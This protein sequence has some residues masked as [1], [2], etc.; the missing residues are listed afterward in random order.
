MQKK[1]A[2]LI[3]RPRLVPFA[4]DGPGRLRFQAVQHRRDSRPPPMPLARAGRREAED[5]FCQLAD[6]WLYAIH[7]QKHGD[8]PG[9]GLSFD[10]AWST[11]LATAS[12]M[13]QRLP[14]MTDYRLLAGEAKHYQAA[15]LE[16]AERSAYPLVLPQGGTFKR[17][18]PPRRLHALDRPGLRTALSLLENAG[19][20]GRE[21]SHA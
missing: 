13:W 7:A 11:F 16:W 12:N 5:L 10:A 1:I 9:D 8:Y 14:V 19:A 6:D 3:L 18:P 20:H 21:G 15:Q 2:G 17:N 4:E